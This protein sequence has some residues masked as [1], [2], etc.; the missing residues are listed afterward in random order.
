MWESWNPDTLLVGTHNGAATVGNSLAA[1]QRLNRELLYDPA[2]LLLGLYPREL[3]T[4]VHTK[5][6]TQLFIAVFIHSS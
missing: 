2:I 4:G 3:K 1:S 6:G 5:T